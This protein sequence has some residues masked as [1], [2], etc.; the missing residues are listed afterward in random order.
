[1]TPKGLEG[2]GPGPGDSDPGSRYHPPL[3]SLKGYLYY[4]KIYTHAYPMGAE[5][6]ELLRG[7]GSGSVVALE[8]PIRDGARLND[9]GARLGE[10]VRRGD[11]CAGPASETRDSAVDGRSYRTV[12]ITATVSARAVAIAT[13]NQQ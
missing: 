11:S 13:A 6:C 5:V 1:M 7:W 8:P 3:F 12:N 9:S 2:L 4:F 10:G